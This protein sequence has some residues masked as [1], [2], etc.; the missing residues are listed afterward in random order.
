MKEKLKNFWLKMALIGL[1]TVAIMFG[2]STGNVMA[3]D[4]KLSYEEY[5]KKEAEKELPPHKRPAPH[6]PAAPEVSAKANLAEAAT[7]PLANLVQFQLQNQYG[8]TNYNSTGSSNTF[9]IQPVVP[10][11]LPWESVPLLITRSTLPYVRTPDLGDP[12]GH[13]QGFGDFTFLAIANP[14]LPKGNQGGLGFSAVF[15]TAGSNEFTG[16][17]KW[18]AGPAYAYINTMI[19]G[20]QLGFFGWH[21]WSYADGP[22]G[23]DRINVNEHSIQPL[24]I[25]H[26][27][28]GWYVGLQDIP[29][30]YNFKSDQWTMPTGPQ[31]GK[32]MKLGKLPV[33]LFG[34]V[35]YDPYQDEDSPS[36]EWTF[37]LNVTLLFPK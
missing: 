23:G 14:K 2:F 19:P 27:G 11:S 26:L 5:K 32:V 37:K 6:S 36:A 9:V 28:K 3:Q 12:V 22:T 15:P 31:V 7:N 8:A 21:H 25:H 13:K 16:S 34:A 18:Q 20:T 33:K 1:C 29:W 35:Y 30:K 24:A 4:H 17:G 10:V